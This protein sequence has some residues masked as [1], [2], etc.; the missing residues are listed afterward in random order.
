MSFA[1]QA[2][3][4]G[5]V[6]LASLGALTGT[7]IYV[8][9]NQR[10]QVKPEDIIEIALGVTERCLATQTST[11]PVIYDVDPPSFVRT[12]YSNVYTSNGVVIY[13]NIV[14]N[15][16]GWQ[17]DRDMMIRLDT[18]IKALVPF[19][20]DTNTVYDGTTNISML[21]VTGLWASLKIGDGTNKF[22]R[23]PAWTNTVTNWVVCYTSYWPSTNGT[24][25]GICYTSG[26]QQ[27]VNYAESWTATGGHVWVTS[28]NWASEVAIVTNEA[29]FGEYPRQIYATDL[30][31]R[32]K[33][34][35]ELQMTA[36]H[37][38]AIIKTR[39]V[40]DQFYLAPFHPH[41]DEKT[42]EEE[43]TVLENLYRSGEDV[44]FMAETWTNTA[45]LSH[46]YAGFRI[47][48]IAWFRTGSMPDAFLASQGQQILGFVP[49]CTS[50]QLTASVQV[51]YKCATNQTIYVGDGW[52]YPGPPML[53]EGYGLI[54]DGC[55]HLIPGTNFGL[56]LPAETPV[57]CDNPTTASWPYQYEG[58][59]DWYYFEARG[60]K[61]ESDQTIQTWNFSY[62]TN[63]YW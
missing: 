50:T 5:W 41:R 31:E 56:D 59:S 6:A 46:G 44:A 28:S 32:Y 24:A 18:T 23:E 57:W 2:L 48:T 9:N 26:Y 60:S 12:W 40:H 22:T 15:T 10:H 29:T 14:T 30:E 39:Q 35:T 43:Q 47:F 1:T 38:E 61:I 51:F 55:Y 58:S 25:V 17:V 11:N 13:T 54:G 16:I 45:F 4:Y 63:K 49:F 21:T 52:P 33:V 37:Q 62:C 42:W 53:F 3:R 7:T 34:L 27:V 20:V 19:Y 36:V 8:L